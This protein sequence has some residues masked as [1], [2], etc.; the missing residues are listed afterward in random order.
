[1]DRGAWQ[2]AVHGVEKSWTRLSDFTFMHWRRKWQP[3]PV[4]LPGESHGLGILVGCRLWGLPELDTTEETWQQ[5]HYS[6]IKF[7]SVTAVAGS[8]ICLP[9][10]VIL[11]Q[12]KLIDKLS[13]THNPETL[14]LIVLLYYRM[15]LFVDGDIIEYPLS[16]HI[17]YCLSQGCSCQFYF[18]ISKAHLF[19]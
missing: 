3:T 15:C 12:S 18:L 19:F 2:A 9:L 6:V 13:Q 1:M 11:K 17:H 8:L 16:L 4:F 5:Q 14:F 10:W 7:T